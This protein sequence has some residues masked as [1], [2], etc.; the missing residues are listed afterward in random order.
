MNTFKLTIVTPERE[1]FSSDAISLL[2]KTTEGDV[3]ILA[4]HTDYF[5]VLSTGRAKLQLPDG[6]TRIASCSGGMISVSKNEVRLLPTTFEYAEEIDLARAMRAK[7]K[8][9]KILASAKE[10]KELSLAKAKL[11]RSICRINIANS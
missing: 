7:E 10:D 4:G 6:S 3:Q 9:E 11:M 8:A 2:V 5:A 1:K